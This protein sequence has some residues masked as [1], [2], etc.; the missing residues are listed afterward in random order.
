M[1]SKNKWFHF[2]YCTR[3]KVH[4][5]MIT[6]LNL[7]LLFS[8]LV[9]MS[10][11]WIAIAGLIFA[12]ALGYRFTIERNAPEFSSNFD[13]AIKNAAQNVHNAMDSVMEK[14]GDNPS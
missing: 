5:G 14:H 1:H 10:A 3:I 4:K 7:S 2:F 13:D 9:A 11:P 12:L 8:L 6:I